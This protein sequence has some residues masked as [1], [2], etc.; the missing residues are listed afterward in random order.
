M[1]T[2]KRPRADLPTVLLHWG[3]VLA[4]LVSVSSGWRIAGMTESNTLWRWID[5][6][7]LQGNVLRWHFLSAALL[8]SLVIGY[9]AFLWRM[10]LSGRLAVRLA[11]LRSPDR[12]TRWQ[13]VNKLIYWIAFALLLGAAVT[14]SL[15][16]FF[17]GALP[18]GPLVQV[19]E[20]LSWSFVAY[21]AL[22]I[23]A[24]VVLGGL[25]Q[26]LKMVSPRLAYGLGAGFAV[27]AGLASAAVTYVADN[28]TLATLTLA[29]TTTPPK[30]DGDASDRVWKLAEEVVVHTARGFNLDGGEVDVH[31]RALH[32]GQSAYFLFRWQDA[33]RSQKHIPLMKTEGGWKLVHTNYYNNDENEFYEDKFAVMLARSPIAAGNASRLG[34][35]PL[36]D[37][38]G[39]ANGLGLHVT[40]DGSL[41]DVWHWKS[42]RSGATHQMDDNYFGPPMEAKPGRYTGG[43]S[44]DPNSGGSYQQN[45]EKIAGSPYVKLKYLPKNLAE[46]QA[47]MGRFN[48]DVNVSD[49]GIYAMHM[50]EVVPYSAKADAAIPVG[51]VIP[52][53]LFDKPFGGDRGDVTAHAQ[54]KDG[55]WTLEVSRKLDTGSKFDLPI[56]DDTYMWVAVFDH[57]QVRHTRHMRPLRLRLDGPS[58]EAW[59]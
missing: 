13:T 43:Y 46:Q 38:P 53:V 51:T 5:V 2:V 16:Y 3:M 59:L 30:L 6:L 29:K 21:I 39:P 54:W 37:K 52:S 45:F 57:N 11:S 44:Q 14:G 47:R 17:P 36:D 7:I 22:H 10:G 49:E 4:L 34:P 56:V 31:V 19:H 58:R 12:T 8:T 42:V 32:D 50:S 28:H 41:A 18:T 24:Q 15:M 25:R 26:L 23:V 20:F 40:T 1:N 33:T 55:W 48:P 35:K 27:V 9:L